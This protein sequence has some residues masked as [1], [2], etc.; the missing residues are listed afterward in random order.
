MRHSEKN[1]QRRERQNGYTRGIGTEL[2]ET[3]VW[4]IPLQQAK[5]S[6]L[7]RHQLSTYQRHASL[8]PP[9]H[10]RLHLFSS[11]PYPVLVFATEWPLTTVVTVDLAPQLPASE[12][13]HNQGAY[14]EQA[15]GVLAQVGAMR[16]A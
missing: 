13:L 10:E 3:G 4:V 15:K 12:R 5:H 2:R 1:S 6:R 16:L 8:L 7:F 9:F 14:G 11:W